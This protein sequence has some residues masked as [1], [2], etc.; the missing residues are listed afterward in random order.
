MCGLFSFNHPL[1]ACPEC[2][3]FGRVIGLDWNK[4][5][6]NPA[7]TLA[8]GA[9]APFQGNVYGESQ[10]D[11]VRACRKAAIPLDVPWKKLSAA[12]APPAPRTRAA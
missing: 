9:I 1:G 2:R 11:L 5:I 12:H 7:L 6:P 4:I 8:E 10:K 3:G